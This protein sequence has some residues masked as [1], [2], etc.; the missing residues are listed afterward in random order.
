MT[1]ISSLCSTSLGKISSPALFARSFFIR[2][3]A[4]CRSFGSLM[5]AMMSSAQ[6]AVYQSSSVFIL[7]NSAMDSR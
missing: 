5:V 7:L 2:L 3:T 4:R 1:G 6:S